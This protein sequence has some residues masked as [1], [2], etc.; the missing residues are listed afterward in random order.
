MYEAKGD[1]YSKIDALIRY[2]AGLSGN[3]LKYAAI[4]EDLKQDD[5][6]VKRYIEVLELMFIL[7]RL[8]P[9]VRNAAKRGVVGMPKLHFIDTGLA[10]HLLGQKKPSTLHTSRFYGS[11]L[12]TLVVS[13]LFKHATWAEDEYRF[14][15]F[16]DRAKNE[17]DVV[18]ENSAGEIVGLEVKASTTINLEDFRG[19]ANLAAYAGEKMR[20]GV[21]FYTG[22][23]LL[24][25][26]VA[27]HTFHA[28][29]LSY[30]GIKA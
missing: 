24:P 25:F 30:L 1:Y 5:K 4:S 26:R 2:L 20:R 22:A 28:V 3:L 29:P 19:L 23:N 15:H 9:Y 13:E 6:T 8:E 14:W 12:E 27:E 21:V 10:C 7:H 16:R 18:L 11:L 17:V